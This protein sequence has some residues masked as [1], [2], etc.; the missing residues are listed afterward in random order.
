MSK[1]AKRRGT[2]PT[3]RD[4]QVLDEVVS[5]NLVLRQKVVAHEAEARVAQTLLAAVLFERPSHTTTI[6]ADTIANLA[7]E[8]FAIE[9]QT[10]DA[11]N[12]LLR[13]RVER[14]VE[15]EPV[16]PGPR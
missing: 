5:Q 15:A 9:R 1:Q 7:G 4:R 2:L 16:E 6:S 3:L 11:G 10:D 12:L 13:V 14:V 8:T